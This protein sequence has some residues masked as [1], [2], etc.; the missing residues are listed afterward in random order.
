MV[1][2]ATGEL[3]TFKTPGI[4]LEGVT[5]IGE[6]Y[7]ESLNDFVFWREVWLEPQSFPTGSAREL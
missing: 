1:H 3:V 2:E 6:S 5:F 4:R 7:F